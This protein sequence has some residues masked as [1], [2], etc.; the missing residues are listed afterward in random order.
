[1]SL[2]QRLGI[3]L[4]IL[5]APMA[6]VQ[7]SGLAVAVAEG[8][9]LGALPCAML[10]PQAMSDELERIRAQT[11]GPLNVNFFC[12]LPPAPDSARDARWH[13]ALAPYYAE[14][15]LDIDSVSSGAGRRPF[16]DQACDVLEAFRP[17]VVSFH[18]GLPSPALLERV[19]AWGATVLSSATTVEEALWLEANGADAVIAQGLEAGGH[20]GMFLTEDLTTQVGTLALL[21]QVKAA[22]TLPVIAAGGIAD[23]RG[24]AAA[25]ALG[26]DAVQVGTAFLCCPEATTSPLHRRALQT[27]AAR[28][29]ALTNLYTGRPARGI[30]TRLMREL[31]P[32]SP[33]AP[34]FPLATAAI[35]PLR[36]A[37]EALGSGDFSPL[38]A[39]QNASGCREV[40]A[41][42]LLRELASEIS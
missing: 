7:G 3:E 42:E 39:G 1:M 14:L 25:L 29:T 23:A 32:I 37:A 22:V 33:L 28:H 34:A 21:P 30:V 10:T 24:V 12:H 17:E 26:A 4:P 6:G 9:G 40:P 19:K 35:G 18:F 13:Q 20:R 15:G 5:Q 16:D 8:G 27:D 11:T 2:T 38:W 36:S 41:A 31:G